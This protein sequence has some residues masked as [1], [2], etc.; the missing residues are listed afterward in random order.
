VN[1][2]GENVGLVLSNV[3][4][5][6][7]IE[8]INPQTSVPYWSIPA[9]GWGG[10]RSAGNVLLWET[11]AAGGPVWFTRSVLPGAAAVLDDSA[12]LAYISDVDTP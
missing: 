9:A 10:G 12:T 8:A 2:Y 5:A 6:D 11:E 7:V 4:I 1:V 3:P